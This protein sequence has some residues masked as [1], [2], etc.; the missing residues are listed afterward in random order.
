MVSIFLALLKSKKIIVKGSLDRFRFYLHRRCCRTL[1]KNDDDKRR[2]ISE[3]NIGSGKKTSVEELLEY[4]NE[5]LGPLDIELE[6]LPLTKWVFF[7][8]IGK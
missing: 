5:V 3:L 6:D 2:R 1:D 7:L 8:I 4:I